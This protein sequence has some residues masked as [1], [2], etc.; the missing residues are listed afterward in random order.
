V[1]FFGEVW[2][3][4]YNWLGLTTVHPAQVSDH[5]LQFGK[6]DGFSK[7]FCYVLHLIWLTCVWIIWHKRNSRVFKQR[8]S[9]RHLHEKIKL[10]S[11]QWLKANHPIFAFSYHEWRFNPLLCL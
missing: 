3:D 7:K 11:Y 5:L 6:I 1:N 9:L 2:F 10:Q 4:I 8:E